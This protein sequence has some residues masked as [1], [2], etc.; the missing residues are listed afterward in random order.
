MKNLGKFTTYA[1]D[2]PATS[3]AHHLQN[4]EGTD[5]Y[6]ISWDTER[7]AKNIYAGTDDSGQII[8]VTD[9]GALFFPANMTAWEIPTEEAPADILT[10]GYNATIID[11]TYSVDYAGLAEKQRQ[12]LLADANT[13]ISYWRTELMMDVISDDDKASLAK[14]MAYIKAVKA[15]DLTGVTN[16]EGYKAIKWPEKL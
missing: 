16:E 5:W 11:G 12:S 3:D 9:N 1:P 6:T 13:T 2:E 14:W 4:S 10:M 15:L 7:T 8:A